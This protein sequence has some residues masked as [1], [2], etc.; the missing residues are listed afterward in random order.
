[1]SVPRMASTTGHDGDLV[2]PHES[3]NMV[4]QDVGGWL[5]WTLVAAV[6]A[7]S[8]AAGSIQLGTRCLSPG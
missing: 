3:S 1:M 6:W 5:E 7:E 4:G 8:V 2:S